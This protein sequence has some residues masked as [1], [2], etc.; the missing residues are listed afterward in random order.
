M[1]DQACRL[2][3]RSSTHFAEDPAQRGGGACLDVLQSQGATTRRLGVSFLHYVQDWLLGTG[4]IPPL[5]D[6]VRQRAQELWPSYQPAPL[7]S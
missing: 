1:W 6:L 2:R 5:A 4:T 3:F 7:L